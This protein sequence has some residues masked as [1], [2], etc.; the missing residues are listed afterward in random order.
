VEE[1]EQAQHEDTYHTTE[2]I[3]AQRILEEAKRMIEL[4]RKTPIMSE[5]TSIVITPVTLKDGG[6]TSTP[7][8]PQL[9]NRMNNR[10]QR[11]H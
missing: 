6:N 1:M 4:Q 10:F 3:G 9:R 11:K 7:G 2:R 8:I 5:V